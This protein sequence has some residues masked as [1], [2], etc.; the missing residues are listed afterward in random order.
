MQKD[1]KNILKIY[2]GKEE[3]KLSLLENG[4]IVNLENQRPDFK[5]EVIKALS[6]GLLFNRNI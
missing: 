2:W 1:K 4:I 5:K 6:F 3:I